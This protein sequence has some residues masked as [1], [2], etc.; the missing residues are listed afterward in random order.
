MSDRVALE[1][2]NVRLLPLHRRTLLS[3]H[4]VSSGND[5]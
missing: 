5:S 2:E 1:H 4:Y 3:L